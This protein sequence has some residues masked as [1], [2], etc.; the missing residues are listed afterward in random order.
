M[1]VFIVYLDEFLE[2]GG[3]G[4]ASPP[5][6]FPPRMRVEWGHPIPQARRSQSRNRATPC[7]H[8]G[9]RPLSPADQ[10]NGCVEKENRPI[11]PTPCSTMRTRSTMRN[12]PLTDKR[13]CTFRITHN[14]ASSDT[15][16]FLLGGVPRYYTPPPTGGR[17]VAMEM[18]APASVPRYGTGP[19]CG[20]AGPPRTVRKRGNGEMVATMVEGRP[21]SCARHVDR[22]TRKPNEPRRDHAEAAH[23]EAERTTPRR[24]RTKPPPNN[25]TPTT[26]TAPTAQT[27]HLSRRK[28]AADAA[29]RCPPFDLHAKKNSEK[30]LDFLPAMRENE[31]TPTREHQCNSTKQPPPTPKRSGSFAMLVGAA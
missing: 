16:Y 30:R 10:P 1:Y 26:Q 28:T 7:R 5:L 6:F 9:S 22:T 8:F 17:L 15:P 14:L 3:G 25:T 13:R 11:V 23:V 29:R 31:R 20:I 27:P 4:E 19:R 24:A 2:I 21:R 18:V 12:S